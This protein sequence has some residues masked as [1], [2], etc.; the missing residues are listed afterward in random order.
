MKWGGS[1]VRPTR[2]FIMCAM[3]VSAALVASAETTTDEWRSGYDKG[4]DDGYSVGYKEGAAAR[5]L[6]GIG[7]GRFMSVCPSPVSSRFRW[8][9]DDGVG[10]SGVPEDGGNQLQL[11]QDFLNGDQNVDFYALQVMR[12][13]QTFMPSKVMAPVSGALDIDSVTGSDVLRSFRYDPEVMR[14]C[15]VEILLLEADRLGADATAPVAGWSTYGLGASE[16]AAVAIDPAIFEQIMEGMHV[17]PEAKVELYNSD[18]FT[19]QN[20]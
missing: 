7:G 4:Y 5:G 3:A 15:G 9:F 17:D 19:F 14:A 13:G 20:Q 11:F 1:P 16:L 6:P 8:K 18:A 12:A 10:E 2:L